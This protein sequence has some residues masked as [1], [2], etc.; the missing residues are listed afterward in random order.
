MTLLPGFSNCFET[1]GAS[2]V[3]PRSSA[4][5]AFFWK[6]RDVAG[7]KGDQNS[8]LHLGLPLLDVLVFEVSAALLP[9]GSW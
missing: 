6:I 3:I 1:S 9:H 8:G 4:I 2:I 7:G 5:V